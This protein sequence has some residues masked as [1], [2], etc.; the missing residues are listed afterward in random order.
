LL[1]ENKN[2]AAP[3]YQNVSNLCAYKTR[4]QTDR[5]HYTFEHFR[6]DAKS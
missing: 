5:C 3:A 2:T 6:N 4:R 1:F